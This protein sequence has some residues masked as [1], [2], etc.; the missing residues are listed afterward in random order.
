MRKH[1]KEG[2]LLTLKNLFEVLTP[3]YQKAATAKVAKSGFEAAGIYPLNK[4]KFQVEDFAAA[5]QT[6]TEE[7]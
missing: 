7:F 3:A 2:K 5:D 6:P 1:R 4:N